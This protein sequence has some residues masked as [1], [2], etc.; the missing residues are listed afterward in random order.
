MPIGLTVRPMPS[1]QP[2]MAGGLVTPTSTTTRLTVNELF[3]VQA[4]SGSWISAGLAGCVQLA[5]L[6]RKW[7]PEASAMP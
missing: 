5:L 3:G 6:V 2:L 1:N 7:S 4:A